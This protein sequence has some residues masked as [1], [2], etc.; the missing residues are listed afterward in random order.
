V[1]EN[2]SVVDY[3]LKKR[4]NVKLVDTGLVFGKEGFTRFRGKTFHD[5][6]KLTRRFYPHVHNMDGFYVAKFKVNKRAKKT[7]EDAVSKPAEEVDGDAE[8]GEEEEAKFDDAA[9]AEYI[10]G[11]LFFTLPDPGVLTAFC[12]L[13]A[14]AI[15]GQGHTNTATRVGVEMG[16]PK[17]S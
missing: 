11:M 8:S 7:D 17:R 3:A 14:K 4:P 5:S 10:K 13:P 2:E 15:E 1:D 16:V 9:D 12:R 6:L